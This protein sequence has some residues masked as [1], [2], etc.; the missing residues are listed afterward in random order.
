MTFSHVLR[1][2]LTYRTW[3]L[4]TAHERRLAPL[5]V[6]RLLARLC[7]VLS[8]LLFLLLNPSPNV[9]TWRALLREAL[10]PPKNRYL[11]S[12]HPV[13]SST[14]PLPPLPTSPM[15]T[16]PIPSH[17]P[18]TPISPQSVSHPKTFQKKKKRKEPLNPPSQT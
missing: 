2:V 16:F 4:H 17:S 12:S 14:H 10:L 13:Q 15:Q 3:Q 7:Y 1:K 18:H 6:L 11:I 9:Q 5:L 8:A